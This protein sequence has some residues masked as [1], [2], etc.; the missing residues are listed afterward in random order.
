[1]PTRQL[2]HTTFLSLPNAGDCFDVAFEKGTLDALSCGEHGSSNI[3]FV[4]LEL[5]R[6]LRPTGTF[7]IVTAKEPSAILKTVNEVRIQNNEWTTQ[8]CWRTRVSISKGGV[9]IVALVKEAC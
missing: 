7:L 6:C 5:L 1:L 9:W 2:N 4:A 3:A 8:Y